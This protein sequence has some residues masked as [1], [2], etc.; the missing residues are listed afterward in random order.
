MASLVPASSVHAT[1]R[2]ALVGSWVYAG[3]ECQGDS[4]ITFRANGHWSTYDSDGTWSLKGNRLTTIARARRPKREA[5]VIL[6]LTKGRLVQRWRDGT[7]HSY[8]R[9]P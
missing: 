2:S 3:D 6:K 8:V 5:I 7:I 1:S 9:C 4:G